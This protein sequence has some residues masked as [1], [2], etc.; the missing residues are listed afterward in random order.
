MTNYLQLTFTPTIHETLSV[1]S[2][3]APS[4]WLS[5]LKLRLIIGLQRT[6]SQLLTKRFKL[7][8]EVVR[9]RI[10]T[11]ENEMIKYFKISDGNE[12]KYERLSNREACDGSDEE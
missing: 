10:T 6:R 12:A 7:E 3:L 1:S 4:L 5:I 11:K 2:C 8:E 9:R